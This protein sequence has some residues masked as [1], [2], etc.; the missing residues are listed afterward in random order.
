[1][2]DVLRILLKWHRPLVALALLAAL[3]A[4]IYAWTAK[5]RYFA[6][7]SILPPNDDS[8]AF[9]GLSSL[10]QQY[11]IPI[12]GGVHTPFLPT[13][14][15]SIVS[16]RKMA[17]IILEEFHLAAEFGATG[18]EDAVAALRARTFLK[19][20][21]DGLF[22]V[23]FQ[24]AD[25]KRGAE[26]ANAYV[27][28]LDTIIQE[29]NAGRASQTRAFVESQIERCSGDLRKA[30]EGLRDFQ[31]E[32][33]AVQIDTQTEGAVDLAATLQA[34]IMASKVELQMLRDK[35]LPTAPEVRQKQLEL[36]AMQRQYDDL[37]ASQ[38]K[39]HATAPD[40][41]SN[42]FLR[43][44]TVPDLA[45]QY[46]RLMRSLKVQETLYT[47][48]VQQLEQARIEEQK[49]TPVLSVLDWAAPGEHPVYPRKMLLVVIA[50]FAA[51]AWVGI[52][53]VCV[54]KV[55][56]RRTNAAEAAELAALSAEW[57]AM[58]GWVRR[59]ERI[60]GR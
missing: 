31:R 42:I 50:A 55:R 28:H 11:Q 58:P 39:L 13:L 17:A 40:D 51:A 59:I 18:Q 8:A 43:F 15:A 57:E 38:P 60:V 20:T 33:H 25:P 1:M 3:G 30:E 14:Y 6:Q 48:L 52:V 12:P 5:P 56:A 35:A 26:V 47:L 41:A 54:E 10:L 36:T 19:Y 24:D 23:G 44:D 9:G 2:L 4:A 27:R 16:S 34:R 7:A 29:V 45:M 37:S 53:A 32:H 22:L 46:L 49:N 21:D